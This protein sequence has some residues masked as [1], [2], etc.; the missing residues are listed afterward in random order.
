MLDELDFRLSA[1]HSAALLGESGSG[2]ST[3]LHLIAGLDRPDRG[4]ILIDGES[5]ARFN[6]S[7]WTALRRNTLGLVFQQY[8]LVPTLNARDNLLLQARLAGRVD[9]GLE[10]RL[11]TRLGLEKLQSRL[12]HQLSGGQQQRVAIARALMHR[13]RLVLADEPTGNLDESTSHEVMRLL[14]ELVQESGAGLLLV[15]HSREMAAYLD[16]RWIL[17]HG[18]VRPAEVRPAHG[19]AAPGGS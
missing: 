1:G 9:S 13:P 17:H 2:K 4:E 5:A 16:S 12:P 15:T 14:V 8:H 11:V 3:L 19:C 10:R 6:E 7:R 18:R